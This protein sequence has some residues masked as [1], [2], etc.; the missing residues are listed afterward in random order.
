MQL[1]QWHGPLYVRAA[2]R[3]WTARTSQLPPR[4]TRQEPVLGPAESVTEPPGYSPCQ[5][6]THSQTFPSMSCNPHAFGALRP[7]G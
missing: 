7:T 5:S 3:L 6:C 2:D 4:S 1:S